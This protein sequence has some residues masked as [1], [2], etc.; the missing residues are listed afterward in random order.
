[1]NSPELDENIK[2]N[3]IFVQNHLL[4]QKQP[5]RQ[6]QTWTYVALEIMKTKVMDNMTDNM[7]R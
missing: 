1:M 6:M 4:R 5:I 3:G 7:N 2:L